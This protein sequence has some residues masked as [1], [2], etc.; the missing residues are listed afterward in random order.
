MPP[1]VRQQVEKTAKQRLKSGSDGDVIMTDA[2]DSTPPIAQLAIVE[3]SKPKGRKKSVP[4]VTFSHP[5]TPTKPETLTNP[6]ELKTGPSSNLQI[7]T[8]L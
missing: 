1:D 7:L 2:A 8:H 6:A 3:R 4:K 5:S